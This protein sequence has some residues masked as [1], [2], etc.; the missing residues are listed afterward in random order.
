VKLKPLI[1]QFGA[2]T[3]ELLDYVYR[4][5]PM[6]NAAPNEILDF[7]L[8]VPPAHAEP[9][10]PNPT[11]RMSTLSEKKKRRFSE[12][13]RALQ[14]ASESRSSGVT[15]LINPVA[16]PRYDAVYEDGVAW[17]D[18][19]AGDRPPAGDA[20]AEFGEDVWKSK[21]RKGSDVP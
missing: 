7:S 2:A 4:T 19:L 11:L 10:P 14:R 1:R 17:L 5:A 16:N 18:E 12:R 21:S 20:I 13:M 3:A 9:Q 6:L 8:V 15:E